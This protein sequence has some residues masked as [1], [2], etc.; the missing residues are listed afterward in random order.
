MPRVVIEPNEL[1]FCVSNFYG[2]GWKHAKQYNINF[3]AVF[4]HLTRPPRELVLSWT[5]CYIIKAM[6]MKQGSDRKSQN[7]DFLYFSIS[8]RKSNWKWRTS[9]VCLR[10]WISLH[11]CLF[12]QNKWNCYR[13][14]WKFRISTGDFIPNIIICIFNAFDNLHS[15]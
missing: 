7:K 9:F 5:M 6:N 14:H 11:I 15:K 4:L 1:L 8:C 13:L 3:D 2:N 10:K 12:L